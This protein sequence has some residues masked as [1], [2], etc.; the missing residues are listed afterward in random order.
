MLKGGRRTAVLKGRNTYEVTSVFLGH[1]DVNPSFEKLCTR[2]FPPVYAVTPSP[3]KSHNH[4][5]FR[6]TIIFISNSQD[7]VVAC[8]AELDTMSTVSYY[9][10]LV[11]ERFPRFLEK[12]TFFVSDHEK[13]IFCLIKENYSRIL[14]RLSEYPL[15]FCHGD[16]KSPNIYFIQPNR[17]SWKT[18]IL[19]WQYIHLNKGVADIAFLLIES[20]K[21]DPLISNMVISYY[22]KLHHEKRGFYTHETFM[23]EF[24]WEPRSYTF[25]V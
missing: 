8:M 10:T 4:K 23:T 22:Y 15:S 11:Q 7:S 21:F 25:S 24:K 16:F 6:I 17:N 3:L 1:T 13:K 19:D 20:L 2:L 12:I 14:G 5:N 9:Q 18:Y